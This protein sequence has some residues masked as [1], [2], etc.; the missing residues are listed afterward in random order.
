MEEVKVVEQQQPVN[1]TDE[2]KATILRTLVDK[3]KEMYKA[4]MIGV[5]G[6][7]CNGAIGIEALKH[8]DSGYLWFKEAI[9]CL[10]LQPNSA[11]VIKVQPQAEV[12][13]QSQPEAMADNTPPIANVCS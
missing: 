2:Q 8:F 13:A 7:P 5:K 6:I 12:Q 11:Q 9:E 3:L 1:L 4:F 10:D